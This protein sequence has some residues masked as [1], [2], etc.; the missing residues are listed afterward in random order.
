MLPVLDS[1]LDCRG[2]DKGSRGEKKAAAIPSQ[3][4]ELKPHSIGPAGTVLRLN[5]AASLDAAG[6]CGLLSRPSVSR[7]S[8]LGDM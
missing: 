1:R 2:Q 6:L 3:S 4:I 5:T 8:S 7:S